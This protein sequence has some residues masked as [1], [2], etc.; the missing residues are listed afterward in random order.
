[1]IRIMVVDDLKEVRSYF[2]EII[3]SQPDMELAGVAASGNEAVHMASSLD[4]DVILMDIQMEY[5]GAGV[6]ATRK[7]CAA[8]P[9]IKIIMLTIYDTDDYVVEAYL[10]G[11]VDYVLKEDD[12]VKICERIRQ[13]YEN[14]NF[15]G[16]Y[17]AK[18]LRSSI[19]KTRTR[20]ES[21][22]FFINSFSKLT[23][24][25]KKILKSL[26]TGKKRSEIADS[27]FISLGT[28][29]THINHILK[30][31]NFTATHDLIGFLK[32]IKIFEE[33]DI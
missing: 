11:A 9:D 33:F 30:K 2:G 17:I 4:L 18:K 32:K 19:E 25:E 13:V 20:E 16:P 21:M 8:F 15:I 23:A 26:Y 27:E 5:A 7:I 12:T 3:N 22:L 28:V 1:M 31:L 29:K 6:D 14:D 10:A 24:M